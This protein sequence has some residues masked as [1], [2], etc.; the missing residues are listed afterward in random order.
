MSWLATIVK[1]LDYVRDRYDAFPVRDERSRAGVLHVLD[2]VRRRELKRAHGRSTLESAAFADADVRYELYALQDKQKGEVIGCIRLTTADQ[3]AAIPASRQEY[4]LDRFPPALLARTW[5]VTRLAILQAYRKTAASLVLFR[6]L[7]DDALAQQILASVLSCEPGLYAG[8][9]RLGY[10]PLGGVHQGASGGFRIPM[11]AIH[12]D[13][14]YLRLI[15]SPMAR[16]LAAAGRALPQDAVQWY[17]ALDGR[18]GRID[19]GV[20]FYAD[21][22]AHDVHAQLTQGLSATGRAQLL[23]NA[24]EVKCRHG[25]VILRAGDGGRN[26]AFVRQGA[27]QLENGSRVVAVL[28]EGELFGEMAMVLDA[29]RAV[30]VVAVGDDTRVLMLSQTCLERLTNPADLTQV[31]R[32]LARVLARRVRRGH[33]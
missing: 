29:P 22:G 18:E 20:A 3:I 15:R 26:M 19:P 10:R 13:D 25:D 17:R 2:E 8:Y 12:H 32:N 9:L 6:T 28:G 14:E 24:L 27:V 1:Y 30:S 16:R 4:H 33:E 23:R 11:V 21:D 7:Y 31:W 5:V